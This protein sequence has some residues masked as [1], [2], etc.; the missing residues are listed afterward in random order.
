MSADGPP[1][2]HSDVISQ[3]QDQVN[4]L[5]SKLFNFLGAL[6]RDAPP[7]SVKGEGLL[8]PAGGVDLEVGAF[9]CH[10]GCALLLLPDRL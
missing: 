5:C 10:E 7:A 6:Q 4:G 3:L 8:A 1:P 9:A 2:R